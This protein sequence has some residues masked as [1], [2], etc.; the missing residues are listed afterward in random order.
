MHSHDYVQ[1]LLRQARGEFFRTG[2]VST[3][4]GTRLASLNY[5][6]AALERAWEDMVPADGEQMDLN[7]GPEPFRH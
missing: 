7:A 2:S 5:N 3:T 4:T 1:D 6:I